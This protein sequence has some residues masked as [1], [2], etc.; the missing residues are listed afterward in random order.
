ML[1]NFKSN[2]YGNHKNIINDISGFSDHSSRD[3][4]NFIY[5]NLLHLYSKG[6]GSKNVV[7]NTLKLYEKKWGKQIL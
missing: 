6:Q 1:N 2:D 5:S 7:N 4:I 3:R